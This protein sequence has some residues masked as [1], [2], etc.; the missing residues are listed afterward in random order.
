MSY[1]RSIWASA[2]A[3][4]ASA[5]IVSMTASLRGQSSPHGQGQSTTQGSGNSGNA[6]QSQN[7][8]AG[9]ANNKSTPTQKSNSATN[10]TTTSGQSNAANRSSEESGRQSPGSSDRGT[11]NSN[12]QM[13]DRT[14][15]ERGERR[16]NQNYQTYDPSDRDRE[17]NDS[18]NYSGQRNYIRNQYSQRARDD[19]YSNENARDFDSDRYRERDYNRD[20]GYAADRNSRNDRDYNRGDYERSGDYRD[21]RNQTDYSR[22]R[23][24]DRQNSDR[25]YASRDRDLDRDRDNARSRD[26]ASRDRDDRSDRYS[27]REAFRASNIRSADIGIWFDRSNREGLVISDL[28]SKGVVSRLGFHEG[29]R[30]VSVNGNRCNRERDF[31]EELFSPDAAERVEV[32]VVRDGREQVIHV[33][34]AQL[35][36]EY[37]YVEHDPLENFGIVLD[38]RYDDRIVVWKVIPR[39]PAYYA[40]I[41]AGDVFS[42]F[43]GQPVTTRQDFERVITNVDDGN[44]PVQIRRGERTRDYTVDVPRFE[45]RAERRTAMRPNYDNQSYDGQYRDRDSYNNYNNNN[46]GRRPALLPRN[47]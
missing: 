35:V 29:D 47:R 41:R 28:A 39:S 31:V 34:P 43:R 8:S 7:G 36:E 21:A 9:T 27:G 19:N 15:K 38:D 44:V 10:N 5:A 32:V 30:I 18:R 4:V 45:R 3:V 24:Y 25:D 6:T 17:F 23:D 22:S 33:E 40:G 37:Q 13:N 46:Y 2:G 14:S 20:R 26:Y 11:T 16:G 42:T 1:R 12:R